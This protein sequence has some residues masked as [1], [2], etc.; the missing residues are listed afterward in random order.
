M[1]GLGDWKWDLE[2]ATSQSQKSVLEISHFQSDWANQEAV[3]SRI[4]CVSQ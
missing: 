2:V 4:L 1:I 3:Q